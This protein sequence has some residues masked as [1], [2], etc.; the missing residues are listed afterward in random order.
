MLPGLTPPGGEPVAYRRATNPAQL[1]RK[2]PALADKA[3]DAVLM[4]I[5]G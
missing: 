1:S 2:R 4:D 5:Q 3:I